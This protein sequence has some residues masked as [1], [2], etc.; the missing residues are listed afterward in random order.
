M[1]H[2]FLESIYFCILRKVWL[3][4]K[5]F[6][7]LQYIVFSYMDLWGFSGKESSCNAGDPGLIPESGRSP[8][9]VNGNPLQYSCWENSM[10]RGPLLDYSPWCH[11]ESDTTEQLSLFTWIFTWFFRIKF[12][13]FP[14]A[15]F[16]HIPCVWFLYYLSFKDLS[17]L[18][19]CHVS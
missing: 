15:V 2:L 1:K 6:S 3:F 16:F 8:R 19:I 5:I 18:V 13:F 10:D 17:K 7:L 11:K 14:S 4:I 12:F 9:E